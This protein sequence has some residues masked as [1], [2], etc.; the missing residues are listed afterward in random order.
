ESRQSGVV[1]RAFRASRESFDGIAMFK[2][3]ACMEGPG[4]W[5]MQDFEPL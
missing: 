4:A 5:K 3:E 2:G 1:C